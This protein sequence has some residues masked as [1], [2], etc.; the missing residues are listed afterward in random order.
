ERFAE[1]LLGLE[2]NWTGPILDNAGI[3]TTLQH[4]RAME[5]EARPAVK[6]NWRFQQ[7]LY[8][9]YFDAFIR[10]RLRYETDLLTAAGEKV[11]RAT[12]RGAL[13]A[14]EQAEAILD[15]AVTEPVGRDLRSRVGELAEA[16]F[17]SIHAQLSVPKYQ[18]IGVERGA[19]LD[20]IDIPLTDAG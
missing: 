1:G 16:L 18:A 7:A 13:P 4:F 6:L 8:R 15:R 12:T 3:D 2:K 11:R 19:T 10:T 20:T 9:A 14:M 17:Q 5:R